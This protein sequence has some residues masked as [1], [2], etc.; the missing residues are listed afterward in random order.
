MKLIFPLNFHFLF[1]PSSSPPI[2][3]KHLLLPTNQDTANLEEALSHHQVHC[4][5][6]GV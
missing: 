4:F 6:G 3:V 2:L 5:G 1:P